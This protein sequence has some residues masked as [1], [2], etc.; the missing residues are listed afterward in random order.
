VV[1]EA[2]GSVTVRPGR[3]L[4]GQV[5]R[6]GQPART[7]AHRDDPAVE[8]S[9]AA[10][11]AAEGVIAMC[12][13]PVICD[14]RIEG[15]LF[16]DR[17]TASPFTD[18]EE[19]LLV[20]LA[21]HAALA[22]ANARLYAATRTQ[23]GQLAELAAVT[24]T[25]TG[26]L[27]S[28]QVA[29]AILAAVPRLLPGAAARLWQRVPGQ[30]DRIALTAEIG[31][32]QTTPNARTTVAAGEGLSGLA[33]QS[34]QPVVSA[35]LATDPRLCNRAWAAAEGF[36][37][38]LI[39]PLLQGETSVGT[40]VILTRTPHA[41]TDDEVAMFQALAAHAAIA[42]ETARLFAELSQT[43]VDLQAAQA[44]LLQ[45]EKLRALGQLAGGVAHTLNNKLFVVLGN[46]TLLTGEVPGLPTDLLGPL[47]AAA[48]E[49]AL[50]V[51]QLQEFTQQRPSGGAPGL[52]D[53]NAALQ[54][55]VA[56]TRPQWK[57]GPEAAGAPITLRVDV[58][59][60]PPISGDAAALQEALT[61]LILNAC[62]AMPAGGTLTLTGAADPAGAWVELTVTDTGVG[63]PPEVQAKLF[64]PFFTTKGVQRRGLGLATAYGIVERHGGRLTAASVPG[65]GTTL[66]LRL[67]TAPP[68]APAVPPRSRRLLVVDDEAAVRTT[69]AALLRTAGHTVVEAATA[70]A[71]LAAVAATPPEVV[72]TDLGMPEMTGWELAHRIHATHPALPVV[73]L[74]GW[75]DDLPGGAQHRAAVA[76][77]LRKPVPLPDLLQTIETVARPA[78]GAAAR[79]GPA[80]GTPPAGE[81]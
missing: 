62:E 20:R 57:D 29:Q 74:T 2:Y 8:Q 18:R 78:A 65:V 36:V 40:L 81:A 11:V 70:A 39:V 59:A 48:E 31:T 75:Q 16:L 42:L 34:R 21:G 3:G 67:P 10:L 38:A 28:A 19:Q 79:Q 69:T 58:P 14:T 71:A 9:F 61:H 23:A 80:G 12:V 6:T 54:D 76:A 35:A 32:R 43:F 5:L 77:I 30:A 27:E 33:L 51:R 1:G 44:T 49:A 55:L 56:L 73:L 63:M 72:V 66:C 50:V 68:R 15:L 7:A 25:L 41:F 64:E 52:V 46:L 53:L 4:G 45:G 17:R 47:Q 24:Q 13:V 37:S 26:T 22:L 60:L